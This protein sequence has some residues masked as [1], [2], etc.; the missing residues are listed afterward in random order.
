MPQSCIEYYSQ[1][2]NP[3]LKPVCLSLSRSVFLFSFTDP[4]KQLLT[5][6][7]N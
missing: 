7:I 1:E 2:S 6:L 3:M 4:N 5:K